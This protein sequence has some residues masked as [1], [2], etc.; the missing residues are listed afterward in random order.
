[1]LGLY[2][3]V[4][5]ALLA[6][7]AEGR[8]GR[9]GEGRRGLNS[10]LLRVLGSPASC[11]YGLR[12]H[13]HAAQRRAMPQWPHNRTAPLLI[14][15]AHATPQRLVSSYAPL[16]PGDVKLGFPVCNGYAVSVTRPPGAPLWAG[17]RVGV[18]RPPGSRS[19]YVVASL[20]F[21]W[22]TGAP[23]SSLHG[24]RRTQGPPVLCRSSSGLH[25]P[26]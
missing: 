13:H 4:R 18:Q 23:C 7:G 6:L 1:M 21:I 11:R 20:Q 25:H 9:A 14:A 15:P 5:L 16:A 2:P 3:S 10:R 24:N 17:L 22:G 8:A 12:H 19:E 26:T